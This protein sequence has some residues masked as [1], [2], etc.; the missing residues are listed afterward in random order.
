MMGPCESSTW[1]RA[2]KWRRLKHTNDLCTPFLHFMLIGLS[3]Y[4]YSR[5]FVTVC[6]QDYV[7]TGG[8]DNFVHVWR[9]STLEKLFSIECDAPYVSSFDGDSWY[10]ISGELVENDLLL[11]SDSYGRIK[12]VRLSTGEE[13]FT[14]FYKHGRA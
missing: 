3:V 14:F 6:R 8:R 5:T 11:F 7:V 12:K 10:S 13:I 2:L 9:L 1:R 4:S